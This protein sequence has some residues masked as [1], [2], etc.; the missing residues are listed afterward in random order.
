MSALAHDLV[1]LRLEGKSI[2]LDDV[3]EHAGE[4]GDDFAEGFPVETR[5]IRERI[6]YEPGEIDRTEQA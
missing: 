1:A 6:E 4:N 3:V 5:T 2:D